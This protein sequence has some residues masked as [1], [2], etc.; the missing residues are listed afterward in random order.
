MGG[1]KREV[2][3]GSADPR[4]TDHTQ[5]PDGTTKADDGPVVLASPI[6]DGTLSP[7]ARVPA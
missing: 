4:P 6:L 1:V 2:S 3:R 5:R 7:V